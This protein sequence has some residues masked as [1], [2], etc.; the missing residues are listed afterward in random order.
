MAVAMHPITS[1]VSSLPRSDL[2]LLSCKIDKTKHQLE[3]LPVSP[4]PVHADTTV[5]AHFVSLTKPK[6][7]GWHSWVGGTWGKWIDGKVLGYRDFAGREA[8]VC[9]PC[10]NVLTVH[11]N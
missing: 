10:L 5:K 2:L 11:V 4:Y 6:S 8:E 9:C 1:V 7:E 3:T